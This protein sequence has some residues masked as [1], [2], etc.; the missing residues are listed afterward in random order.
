[1]TNKDMMKQYFEL[2]FKCNQ[3]ISEILGA[4]E[5]LNISYETAISMI[6]DSS[7]RG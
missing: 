6:I 7:G 2:M 4:P 3:M 5:T 1:M